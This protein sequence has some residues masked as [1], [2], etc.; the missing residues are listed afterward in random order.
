MFYVRLEIKA[1]TQVEVLE[2][3]DSCSN[4]NYN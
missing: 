2:H 4:K 3:W 1:E